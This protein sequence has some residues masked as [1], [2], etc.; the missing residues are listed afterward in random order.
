MVKTKYMNTPLLK[1]VNHIFEMTLYPCKLNVF[2][3]STESVSSIDKSPGN[4]QDNSLQRIFKWIL[5]L[6]L[7]DDGKTPQIIILLLIYIIRNKCQA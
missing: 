6:I 5:E 4:D 7:P 2:I 1:F 3:S